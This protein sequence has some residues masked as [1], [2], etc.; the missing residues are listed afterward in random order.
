I[1]M[2]RRAKTDP[3]PGDT[4]LGSAKNKAADRLRKKKNLA[5]IFDWSDCSGV[6]YG[7]WTGFGTQ[8]PVARHPRSVEADF[9]I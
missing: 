2:S 5:M 1:A 8:R 6:T 9:L 4:P 7:A 3:A